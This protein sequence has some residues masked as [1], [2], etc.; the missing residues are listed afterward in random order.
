MFL[1]HQ[2]FDYGASLDVTL[3]DLF[4]VTGSDR[5]VPDILGIHHNDGTLIADTETPGIGKEDLA[6]DS[7]FLDPFHKF[8]H[9]IDSFLGVTEAFLLAIWS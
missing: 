8:H 7:P 4:D 1:D 3:K 2:S 6:A 5:S 9:D